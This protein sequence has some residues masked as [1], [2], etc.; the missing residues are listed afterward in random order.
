MEY[1]E[2][3]AD[4]IGLSR[5]GVQIA[6]LGAGTGWLSVA[7]AKNLPNA[8]RIVATEMRAG[9][10]LRWLR[11]LRRKGCCCSQQVRTFPQ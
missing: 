1:F 4:D 2:A 6:E 5:P 8:E 11:E 10:A 9:G 3:V 7:L